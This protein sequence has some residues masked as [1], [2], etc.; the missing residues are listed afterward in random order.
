MMVSLSCTGTAPKFELSNQLIHEDR[1]CMPNLRAPEAWN[2]S[3]PIDLLQQQE[4]HV[5]GM[6]RINR[7]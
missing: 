5:R 7:G 4:E 6:R 1:D 2:R 3:I